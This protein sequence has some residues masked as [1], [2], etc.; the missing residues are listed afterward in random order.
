MAKSLLDQ[1]VDQ[2]RAELGLVGSLA[3]H[4]GQSESVVQWHRDKREFEVFWRERAG[5]WRCTIF[6]AKGSEDCIAQID[7]HDDKTVR[8]EAHEPVSVTV[9]PKLSVLV[10]VRYG[11]R[12]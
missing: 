2:H 8:I 11:N 9:D 1:I 6:G 3:C 4:L 10:L 7:L 12:R 5:H